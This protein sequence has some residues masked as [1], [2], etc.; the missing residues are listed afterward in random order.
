MRPP[1]P[2][3]LQTSTLVSHCVCV[4]TAYI[5]LL[6]TRTHTHTPHV[7][8]MYILF[9]T[10]P[11]AASPRL[12]SSRACTHRFV[13]KPTVLTIDRF[14]S[15]VAAV[16]SSGVFFCFAKTFSELYSSSSD[17]HVYCIHKY[18]DYYPNY[19]STDGAICSE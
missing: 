2:I 1:L 10:T 4:Y 15:T 7:Y 9:S 3:L 11:S 6:N 18:V 5:S 16:R 14:P 12:L 17:Y 8:N 19:Y 13:Y